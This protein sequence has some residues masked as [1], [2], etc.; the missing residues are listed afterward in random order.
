MEQDQPIATQDQNIVAQEPVATPPSEPRRSQRMIA[1]VGLIIVLVL[2]VLLYFF[3]YQ[4]NDKMT[5][6]EMNKDITPTK[7]E[8]SPTPTISDE[9]EI[10]AV[11][12]EASNSSEFEAI[13]DDINSL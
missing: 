3:F 10:E 5:Y 7:S 12:I 11:E 2:V 4:K 6:T 1:I 9:Q 13:Q 8:I